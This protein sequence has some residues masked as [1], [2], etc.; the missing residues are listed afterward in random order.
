[1]DELGRL[2]GVAEVTYLGQRDYSMR[3]W[4]DPD[5]LAALNLTP[6]D[7]VNAIGEQNL[8]VA[9]G[10]IGQQPAPSSQQFQL[11]IN[12]LGRLTDPDQFSN[13]I[14]KAAQGRSTPQ[15]ASTATGSGMA[16]SDLNSQGGSSSLTGPTPQTTGIVRLRDVA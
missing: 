15:T 8:Q 3:A 4:L 11:T 13:I 1:K 16:A 14:V 7:V 10:Q 9:A 2:P 12:T 5:K 6:L